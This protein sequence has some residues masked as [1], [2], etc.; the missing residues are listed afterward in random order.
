MTTIYDVDVNELI[1]KAA[2]EL[3][4]IKEISPPQW[5]IFAKT[6]IHK[7]R[8]PAKSDWWYFRCAAILRVVYLLGPVGTAKLRVRYGG[9]KRRGYQP[10]TFKKGSGS[11]IRK[12]LQQLEKAG[13]IFQAVKKGHKGRI[14]TPKGKS[15]MDKI[16]SSMVQHAPKKEKAEDK[17][18]EKK[19]E[20]KPEAKE[21][22]K[23]KP[24]EEKKQEKI[25]KPEE[26][27]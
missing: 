23:E 4:K 6:G 11:V 5:A 18:E 24:K 14:I 20:K 27:K 2:E 3:K 22:K 16:A 26:E 8:P 9:K 19:E 1:E 15:F 7:Q 12:A 21:I 10:P 25:K 13:L 17:Q